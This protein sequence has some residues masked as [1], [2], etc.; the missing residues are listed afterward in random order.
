MLR[1]R[2][3][4]CAQRICRKLH[5][6]HSTAKDLIKL[7]KKVLKIILFM[8]VSMYAVSLNTVQVCTLYKIVY[9]LQEASHISLGV[10]FIAAYT[11]NSSSSL[12]V[13]PFDCSPNLFGELGSWHH[14]RIPPEGAPVRKVVCGRSHVIA[15]TTE[16]KG[17]ST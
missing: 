12:W 4:Q 5:I 8:T 11:P 9:N 3:S 16:G 6:R 1:S 10:G 14:L 15:L 7:E 17:I 2:I 13:Q